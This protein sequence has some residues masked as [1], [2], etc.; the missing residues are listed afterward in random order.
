MSVI[1]MENNQSVLVAQVEQP[2]VRAAAVVGWTSWQKISFRIAFIFCG[3]LVIPTSGEWYTRLFSG[4]TFSEF[5]LS[6]TGIRPDFITITSESGRWGLASYATWG[7]ALLIAV[8]GALVWTWLVRN[9]KRIDYHKLYYWLLVAVRYRIAIGIIA[10]GFIKVFPMQMPYPSIANLNTNFGDYTTYKLY[11]QSVGVVTWYQIFL[12]WVEV[13]GGFLLFFRGTAALGAVIN[14][15]VLYNIAHA[16]HAYDGGVHVYSVY[17]V[18]LSLFVVAYEAPRLYRLLWKEQDVQPV[19]YVPAPTARWQRYLH[20]S[21]KWSFVFVFVVVLGWLRYDMHYNQGR[22]KEPV[23][24]GLAGAQG[25]YQVTEFRLNNQVLPFSPLDSIRWHD[26][27]FEKYS[28]FVF[29]TNRALPVDL[30]NGV[31]Q[32]KDI[33]RSYE[34]AGTAGGRR[35]LYYE[36]D[37]VKQLLYL[38]DKFKRDPQGRNG[39]TRKKNNAK[40]TA[41]KPPVEKLVWHYSRPSEGRIILSGLN[42]KKDSIYV[43]LDRI[44]KQYPLAEKR[45]RAGL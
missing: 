14:A 42:E 21:A 28:T 41:S 33:D 37:T 9:S 1:V 4:I 13:V 18:L 7:I 20:R 38:Q 40:D 2:R 3:L 44:D 24:P 8:L 22:L 16:N 26:A 29:K 43:V 39:G 11:W 15:G 19:D 32:T 36:A 31:P 45:Y 23:S 6:L 27:V 30:A 10:F 25:Y 35:Y 17:F 5:I 12:G 34:F